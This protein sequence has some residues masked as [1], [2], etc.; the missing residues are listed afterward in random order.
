MFSTKI[1][2]LVKIKI[3]IKEVFNR[4]QEL[5]KQDNSIFIIQNK[6]YTKG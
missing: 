2:N 6:A 1:I 3:Y 5:S 4:I